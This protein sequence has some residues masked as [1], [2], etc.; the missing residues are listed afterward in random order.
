MWLALDPDASNDLNMCLLLV[1]DMD[2]AQQVT[3]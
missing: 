2:N 1:S 3:M